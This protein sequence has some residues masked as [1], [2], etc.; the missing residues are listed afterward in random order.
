MDT[1]GIIRDNRHVDDDAARRRLV[2]ELLWEELKL[3]DEGAFETRTKVIWRGTAAP[4]DVL[5]DN[6]RDEERMPSSEVPGRPRH[7]PDG[8]RLPVR[9]G[10]PFPGRGRAPGP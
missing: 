2:K 10:Q 9:R 6:V 4:V 7:D 1:E 8:H 5:M 3:N